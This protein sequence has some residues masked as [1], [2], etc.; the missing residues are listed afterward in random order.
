MTS[1][2]KITLEEGVQNIVLTGPQPIDVKYCDT[3]HFPL[4]Y[5]ENSHPILFKKVQVHVEQPP[6]K[7]ESEKVEEVK[8]ETKPDKKKTQ[9]DNFILIELSKRGKKKHVTYVF[10]L[11]KFGL[12]LKD[13]AKLF[14]KKFACSSTVTKE[15]NGQEGITLTGEFGY[16]IVDFLVEKFPTIK[17]EMCQVKEPKEK[18]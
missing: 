1:E 14:S 4:E 17:P 10:N 13:V 7:K 15:D 18:K 5:C 16:E 11:E 3:C 8:T 12:N 2:N 9:K 6:E